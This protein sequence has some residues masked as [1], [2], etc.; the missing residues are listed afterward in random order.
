MLRISIFF[1]E[2]YPLQVNMY[3]V[4]VISN[5]RKKSLLKRWKEKSV[6]LQDM[7]LV[8]DYTFFFEENL[9]T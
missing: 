9:Q 5:S 1:T 4:N 7:Y 2:R 6:H 3:G 8:Y